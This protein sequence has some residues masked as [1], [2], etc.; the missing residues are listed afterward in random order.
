MAVDTNLANANVQ[1]LSP[2]VNYIQF[3]EKYYKPE[4]NLITSDVTRAFL[5]KEGIAFVRRGTIVTALLE[6]LGFF[7][8]AEVIKNVIGAYAIATLGMG[9]FAAMVTNYAW[10][11]RAFNYPA[12][13]QQDDLIASIKGVVEKAMKKR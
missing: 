13:V 11:T 2:I 3:Q 4:N 5:S 8:S 10:A 12:D 7:Q 9:N 6:K 1:S